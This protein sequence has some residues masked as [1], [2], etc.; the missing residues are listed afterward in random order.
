V[1]PGP[2]RAPRRPAVPVPGRDS[3]PGRAASA[4][5]AARTQPA[6]RDPGQRP[7]S[8]AS[9]RGRRTDPRPMRTDPA[10]R[11]TAPLPHLQ[12][13]R[14]RAL[15][16]SS[17]LAVVA[18]RRAGLGHHHSR[19]RA[20]PPRAERP[21]RPTRPRTRHRRPAARRSHSHGADLDVLACRHRPL[22]H[23]DHRHMAG[24]R[25]DPRRQRDRRPRPAD[26]AAK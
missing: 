2:A 10:D 19:Q 6:R 16:T 13:R 20:H 5:P 17:Y 26:R 1:A 15:V 22:G 7:A 4:L 24:H 9:A 18:P 14:P 3:H 8:P 25:P 11:R 23:R 12:L 21:R